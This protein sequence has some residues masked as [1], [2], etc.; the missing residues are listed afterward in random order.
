MRN[1]CSLIS[2]LAALLAAPLG[3]ASLS[4]D[5]VARMVRADVVILGEIHDNPIH[6][7]V[8]TDALFEIQPKAVVWEMLTSVEAARINSALIGEPEKLERVL[9]WAESGWP[10]FSMYHPIFEAAP[11][12]RIF[13]GEV[14]RAATL[15]VLQGGAAVAF[16]A[17]AARYGLTISLPPDEAVERET[18][19]FQAHCE[20]IP[21]D[22]LPAMV[23]IQRLRDAVLAREVIAA[24]DE[25]GGPVAVI[26][27]NG[28]A[29]RDWGVPVFLDRVRPGLNVFVL[30][31]SEDGQISGVFDEVLDAPS[32][33]RDDPCEAFR[34]SN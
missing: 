11:E 33:Q 34:K 20:A 18:L 15:A 8:Q 26:T 30:G 2:G 24:L 10:D 12:A 31:Q 6:H 1:L 25:T 17:D 29:R 7:E 23:D 4:D 9:E 32:V 14:P 13:G 3:A 27:G 16:G 22:K 5:L 19:Q 21:S 28:H